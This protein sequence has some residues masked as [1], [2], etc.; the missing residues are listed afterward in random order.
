MAF[1]QKKVKD[2]RDYWY[3]MESARVDGQPRIVRQRYLGTVESIEAAFDAAFEPESIDDVE[4]GATAT[5]WTLAQRIG[6]GLSVD[7]R[8]GRT[9]SGLSVGTYLQ[10]AA[11]NRAVSPKSKRGS[12]TG[13]TRACWPGS[14][15]LP[16]R[17]GSPRGSGTPCT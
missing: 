5:M 16:P 1:L 15:L 14:S 3:V 12:S 9:T 4:F 7:A 11:V 17:H 10:A 13:T 2:G 8:L 6:F